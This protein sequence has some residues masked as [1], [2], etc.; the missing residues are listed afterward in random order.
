[1]VITSNLQFDEAKEPS[2]GRGRAVDAPLTDS[3]IAAA[4]F[5][6]GTTVTTIVTMR[7]YIDDVI[8]FQESRSLEFGDLWEG[9]MVV[10]S[11]APSVMA[12]Q[13]VFPTWSCNS[14][15]ACV[16]DADCVA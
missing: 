13:D 15:D 3:Y 5:F 1:M 9:A 2:R 4:H 11:R 8:R 16:S 14:E 12:L 7:I 6:G 10:W